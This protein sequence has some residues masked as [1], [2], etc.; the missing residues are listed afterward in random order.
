MELFDIIKCIF[1]NPAAYKNASRI[2]KRKNFFMLQRRF[3]IEHP[4]QANALN[5]LRINQEQSVDIWNRF[6]SKKYNKTPFWMYT[7]GIKKA[8]EEKEKKL[9]ISS[10]T[11]QEYSRI[12]R[13]DI[14]AVWDSIKMFPEEMEK[15]LKNF[16]KQNK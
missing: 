11:V 8:K 6:L 3:S 14:K 15:E 12:Y 1:E 9:N 5:R 7:K 16:E 4:M 13:Y 10:S 2:D